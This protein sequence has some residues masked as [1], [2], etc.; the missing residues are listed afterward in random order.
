MGKDL[1]IFA[2][3]SAIKKDRDG[4]IWW[5]AGGTVYEAHAGRQAN[6]EWLKLKVCDLDLSGVRHAEHG[7]RF[8]NLCKV[9]GNKKRP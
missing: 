6:A 2:K 3:P 8:I 5:T 7:Q 9:L 4:L 1:S